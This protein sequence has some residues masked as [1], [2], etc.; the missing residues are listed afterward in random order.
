MIIL[1][2]KGTIIGAVSKWCKL[3]RHNNKSRSVK[4]LST[5]MKQLIY[6]YFTFFKY[7]PLTYINL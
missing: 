4:V 5:L 1:Q 7:Q 3:F 6:R 2:D